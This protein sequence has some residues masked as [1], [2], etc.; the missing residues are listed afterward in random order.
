MDD[1]QTPRCL[2]CGEENARW[3]FEKLGPVSSARYCDAGCGARYAMDTLP[4]LTASRMIHGIS[5]SRYR[6]GHTPATI[7]ARPP[8]YSLLRYGG[9]LT[10]AEYRDCTPK[11]YRPPAWCG[12]EDMA[13]DKLSTLLTQCP[14]VAPQPS[15]GEGEWKVLAAAVMETKQT[16]D[17]R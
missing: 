13:D 7:H 11:S 8:V 9:W 10:Q 4:S 12:G 2:S 1:S 3:A 15:T 5:L 16:E 17:T 6:E 14:T